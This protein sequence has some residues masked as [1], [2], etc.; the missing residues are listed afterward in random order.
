MRRGARQSAHHAQHPESTTAEA[1]PPDD[2][3]LRHSIEPEIR[4]R[5]QIVIFG[6]FFAGRLEIEL[7]RAG[8]GSEARAHRR[9]NFVQ[10]AIVTGL[11]GTCSRHVD[12]TSHGPS[13]T[14]G[15]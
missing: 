10:G 6:R 11:S 14:R 5:D 13:S 4:L 15:D 7:P 2:M 12:R 1:C 3:A 9:T 8:R